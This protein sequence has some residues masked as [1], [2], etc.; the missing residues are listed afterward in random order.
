MSRTSGWTRTVVGIFAVIL[1]FTACGGSEPSSGVRGVLVYIGGPPEVLGG[2]PS[3]EP[4]EVSAYAMDGSLKG[5]AGFD[6]SHAATEFSIPLE[7][8]TYRLVGESG[9]ALCRDQDVTVVPG[10]YETVTVRCDIM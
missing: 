1:A 9:G 10:R 4:G 8:G 3:P 5:D 6:S 7:P 2:S